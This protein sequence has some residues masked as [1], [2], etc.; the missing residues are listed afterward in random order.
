MLLRDRTLTE[1]DV[2]YQMM[3]ENKQKAIYKPMYS[4]C[5]ITLKSN[6]FKDRHATI[7]DQTEIKM[8]SNSLTSYKL[9]KF[10][11]QT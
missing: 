4:P 5:E 11:T 1:K 10:K 6:Q 9:D 2:A 8:G 3:Q 7:I